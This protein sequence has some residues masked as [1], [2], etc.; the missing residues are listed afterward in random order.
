MGQSNLPPAD[1]VEQV[2]AFTRNIEFNFVSWE[3]N[4]IW[5]KIDQTAYGLSGYLNSSQQHQLVISYLNLLDQTNQ[6]TS[7]I[8]QMYSD[9]KVSDPDTASAGLR[10][11]VT[12]NDTRLAQLAPFTETILQDQVATVAAELGV[13]TGGETIP[14]VSYESTNPPLAL[15]ISPRN[16][17]QEVADISLLPNLTISQQNAL[18]NEVSSKLNVSA[19][20]VPV[21]GI[22]LYPTM[23]L[24]T[25]DMNWLAETVAHEWT[26][27]FLTLHPL[28]ASYDLSAELRNINETVATLSG[29]EIGTEVIKQYYPE[30]VPPPST[31]NSTGQGSTSPPAFNFNAEMH[32]TR[33]TTD[34]LLA[35]GKITE[36][37]NYM[38]TRRQFFLAH[39]YQIRKLN[40]AYFAFYGAYND[41]AGGGSG[42]AGT[43]PVGP[44][45]AAMRAK[46]P[47]LGDF[48]NKVAWMTS[49]TQIEQAAK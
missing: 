34:Q 14:P 15:I 11:K 47:T 33:V 43:D 20:V 13:A 12:Q 2:R 5:Q 35:A 28:G 36:A 21:G 31:N 42:A 17:I 39:G 16:V 25:T 26:H 30:L 19:L 48:L 1:Q 29:R 44:A 8:T 38:E 45:V 24:Y 6:L 3:F 40:Q 10:Q 18:E 23:V 46:S 22:G 4:A 37:E 49:L 7:Q 27:N 41:V 32:L 9:P